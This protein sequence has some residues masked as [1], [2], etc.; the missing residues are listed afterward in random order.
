VAANHKER[1]RRQWLFA[2]DFAL[3]GWR[4]SM[5]DV[6]LKE[7]RDKSAR[8]YHPWLYSGAVN[9]I[10]GE[11][12]AGELVRVVDSDRRFVAYGYVNPASKIRVRLLEWNE[13][14]QV[15]NNWWVER[16]RQAAGNRA[17]LGHTNETTAYR[18]VFGESDFL[19]GLIVDRYGDYLV[20]QFMTAGAERVKPIILNELVDLL[21]PAGIYERSDVDARDL[22]GLA[23]H[24]GTA[25]GQEPPDHVE[26]SEYGIRFRVDLKSGQKTG[27]Y[28]DQREN[29]H[30]AGQYA[31][32]RTV[33]DCFGY[34]GGFAL[35]AL[36][37][38]AESI[39][40]VDASARSLAAA[41]ENIVLNGLGDRSVEYVK[42][43]AFDVLRE[44]RD[45]GRKYGMVIL[46][47]PKFATSRDQVKKALGAYKDINLLGM[48]LLSPGG[49]LATFSCSGAVSPESFRMS[50]LWAALDAGRQVQYLHQLWQP[51]DHPVLASF[52]ES[53]YLTGCICRVV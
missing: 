31:Q 18:L 52:P 49:I 11:P 20:A 23:Q 4:N 6:I 29:R 48:K 44:Y 45:A 24:K 22:E 12:V 19:P 15:D 3:F 32:G 42:G 5:N 34:T 47:P 51:S 7:G 10:T 43:D 50:I 26:I 38:G 27:F 17:L 35:H 14:R 30:T 33:L 25:C 53:Q 21:K 13:R 46:D 40:L 1:V 36:S 39:T 28:L 2:G 9:E 8:Q 37:A 41:Q 16:V